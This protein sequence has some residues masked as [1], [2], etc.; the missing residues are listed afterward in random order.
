MSFMDEVSGG[1]G[2]RLLKFDGRAGNYV[3]RGSDASLDNQ[4]FIADI[5]AARGGYIKFGEKGQAPERH[6]GSVF[7]KD[8]APLR[9]SLG[10][11]D[12]AEWPAAKFGGDEPE[13]P[14]TQVIEIPLRHKETGELFNFTAQSRTSLAAAKDFLAQCRRLPDAFEPVVRLCIGSF[15]GRFGVVKK[16]LLSIV[17]KVPIEGDAE[18]HPFDDEIPGF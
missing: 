5:Y 4:G 13:D 12:R 17:G 18:G 10:N 9:A 11:I 15:K 14:W 1:G 8:E 3:V 6:L 16:P 7:P 2:A